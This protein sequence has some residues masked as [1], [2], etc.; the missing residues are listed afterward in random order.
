MRSIFLRGL[1]FLACLLIG[2]GL[3]WADPEATPSRL[4]AI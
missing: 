2:C 1:T 4:P 3:A